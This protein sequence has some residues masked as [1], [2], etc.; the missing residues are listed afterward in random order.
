MRSHEWARALGDLSHAA[1]LGKADANTYNDI[2]VCHFELGNP[3]E[4]QFVKGDIFHIVDTMFN[5]RLAYWQGARVLKNGQ[6][7]D[8]KGLLMNKSS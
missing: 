3:N 1:A 2:G 4:L 7:D 6:E 8:V 5:G